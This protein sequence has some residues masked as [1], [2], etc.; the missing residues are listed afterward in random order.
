MLKYFYK[1]I[2]AP[3]ADFDALN[4]Q[5]LVVNMYVNAKIFVGQ[6]IK[7]KFAK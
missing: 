3:F 5:S 1:F 7:R 4:N 2:L 6:E